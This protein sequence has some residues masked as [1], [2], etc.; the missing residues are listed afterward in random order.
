MNV[1]YLS[2]SYVPSRRASGVHVMKMC[3]ALARAGHR[4]ELVTKRCPEREE[5]GVADPF[6]FY[7]VEPSFRLTGVRRPDA[8]GGGLVYALGLLRLLRARRGEVDLVYARDPAGAWMA[9][10]LGLPLVFEAHRPPGGR[11]A[12]RLH[13][14]L[15]AAPS[16][17]RLVVISNA[18]AERFA[19]AGLLP[20]GDRAVVAHDAADPPLDGSGATEPPAAGAALWAASPEPEPATPPAGGSLATAGGSSAA[21]PPGPPRLGYVG[22]LYPG[23]GVELLAVLAGRLPD[24]ELHVI[25]GSPADLARWQSAGAPAN[26]ILHGFVPPA[27]L[28]A[29]TRGFD[30]LL[31]PYQRRVAVASGRRYDS[32]WFSPMKLFEYMAA[33]RAIVSSD[34]PVL[35]EVLRNGDTAL[36]VPPDDLDAWERAVRRL[37]AD[38]AERARLGR[39]ARADLLAHHT[40]D[41]RARRV[42]DGL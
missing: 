26:L 7:G 34:L 22:H 37:L 35:R 16:F 39:A 15:F 21:R 29:R 14:G 41:A 6:A 8:R 19:A 11:L 40:W 20:E 17:R 33:G 24:C 18:L 36:L 31:M 38:P 2:L 42:L 27:E 28:P 32:G 4:V 13:R 23:R 3:A 30:V 12:R 9:A 1:L 5:P 10:R 25:G